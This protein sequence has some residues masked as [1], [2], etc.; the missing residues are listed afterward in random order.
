MKIVGIIL[1]AGCL[2][3]ATIFL[4]SAIILSG[5]ISR[6]ENDLWERKEQTAIQKSKKKNS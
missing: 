5:I 2:L 4:F 3:T 1:I 6:E